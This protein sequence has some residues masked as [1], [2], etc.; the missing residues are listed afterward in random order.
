MESALARQG[1]WE[2][3]APGACAEAAEDDLRITS[4]V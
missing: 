1:K 2:I 4:D 3:D